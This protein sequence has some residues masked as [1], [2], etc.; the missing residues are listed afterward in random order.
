MGF[1][2]MEAYEVQ[3]DKGAWDPFGWRHGAHLD[4]GVGSIGRLAW[5]C[6][7]RSL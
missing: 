6:R 7:L 5:V 1:I 4:G 2:W 3:L